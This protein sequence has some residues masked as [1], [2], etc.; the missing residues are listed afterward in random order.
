MRADGPPETLAGPTPFPTPALHPFLALLDAP[1]CCR[2]PTATPGQHLFFALHL[3]SGTS[4]FP[5]APLPFLSL[6]S[7]RSTPEPL[8]P[9]QVWSPFLGGVHFLLCA[10]S[11][12]CII[13]TR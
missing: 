12:L 2:A 6:L 4:L 5:F 10:S 3:P 13:E 11:V 7:S 8:F 9:F 1:R